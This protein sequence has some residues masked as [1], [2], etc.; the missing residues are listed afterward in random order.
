MSTPTAPQS[1]TASPT[2]VTE[3]APPTLYGASSSGRRVTIQDL[4]AAKARTSGGRC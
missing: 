1:P 4:Y 2:P 3:S